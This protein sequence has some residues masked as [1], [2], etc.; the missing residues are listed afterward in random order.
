MSWCDPDPRA[1]DDVNTTCG[2]P[3]IDLCAYCMCCALC[4]GVCDCDDDP[5]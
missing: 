2:H 5:R 4:D 3:I 1:L